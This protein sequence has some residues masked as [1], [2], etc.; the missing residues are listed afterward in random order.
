MI[1]QNEELLKHLFP[2]EELENKAVNRRD[3]LQIK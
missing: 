1:S 3:A 2:E